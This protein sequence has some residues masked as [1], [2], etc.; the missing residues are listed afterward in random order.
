[1]ILCN[2]KVRGFLWLYFQDVAVP[3]CLSSWLHSCILVHQLSPSEHPSYSGS[4][5]NFIPGLILLLSL[6]NRRSFITAS[7]VLCHFCIAG[8]PY[9]GGGEI[10]SPSTLFQDPNFH[11]E[12]SFSPSHFWH[13]MSRVC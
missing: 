12:V 11:D 9:S 5:C 8:H 1:L 3:W 13:Q 10:L 4:P 7:L 6:V 2:P